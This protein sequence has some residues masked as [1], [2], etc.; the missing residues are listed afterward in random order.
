MSM[1]TEGF[2]APSHANWSA[3]SFPCIPMWLGT[4]TRLTCFCRACVISRVSLSRFGLLLL[5]SVSIDRIALMSH[6]TL[7][8]A[9]RFPFFPRHAR[10][11][12]LHRFLQHK[13]IHCPSHVSRLLPLH[14]R[15]M[16]RCS[17][18][19]QLFHRLFLKHPCNHLNLQWDTS[20]VPVELQA[21][22]RKCIVSSRWVE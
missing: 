6:W 4:H 10:L 20:I 5:R 12:V 2:F 17:N 14:F 16:L 13:P 18:R 7:L 8:L 9:Y 1:S 11:A 22:S 19:F 3:I 21:S 15:R